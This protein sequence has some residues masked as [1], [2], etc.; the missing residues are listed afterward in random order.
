MYVELS[1][2]KETLKTSRYFT[3]A[4]AEA[5]IAGTTQDIVV[6]RAVSN[7]AYP[8][9]RQERDILYAVHSP[10]IVEILGCNM[11]NKELYLKKIRGQNIFNYTTNN[12]LEMFNLLFLM[13]DLTSTLS[14]LHS[15]TPKKPPIV[16]GDISGGN[17]MVNPKAS[18]SFN[19]VMIDFQ[20]SFFE[21][22][23]PEH[24]SNIQ[25]GTPQYVAPE[26]IGENIVN[27]TKRDVYSMGIVFY[28]MF[29]KD[30]P[31]DFN[32]IEDVPK[33]RIFDWI[34]KKINKSNPKP[35][36]TKVKDIDKIIMSMI[37]KDYKNRCTAKE[38]H[39][40][41]NSLI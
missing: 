26:A 37:E 7:S 41:F 25:Y 29:S 16:Q 2:E 20:Y 17:I 12:T 24:L 28:Y 4:F 18:V 39:S 38:A 15:N 3:I 22:K 10:G 34:K 30:F 14:Y 23:P 11:Q 5:N 1:K 27:T 33:E 35:I 19:P 31:Y 8:M 32:K 36:S 6:K 9:W 13:T 40:A 21:N